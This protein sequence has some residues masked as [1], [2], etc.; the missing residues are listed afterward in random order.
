M[1]ILW[2]FPDVAGKLPG[3]CADVAQR[4]FG[5]KPDASRQLHGDCSEFDRKLPGYCPEIL[6]VSSP[7]FARTLR[8]KPRRMVLGR[9]AEVARQF[10]GNSANTDALKI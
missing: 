10:A 4:L 8:R 7:A 3:Y 2:T 5:D 6:L 9:C 1:A